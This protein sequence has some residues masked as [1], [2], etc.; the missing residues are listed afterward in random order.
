MIRLTEPGEVI[1]AT[2]P[3]PAWSVEIAFVELAEEQ[4][5]IVTAASELFNEYIRAILAKDWSKM[6][7]L[8]HPQYVYV[9]SNGEEHGGAAAARAQAEPFVTAFPDLQME[10]KRE[11]AAGDTSVFEFIAKGTH[12]GDLMGMAPTGKSVTMPVCNVIEVRDG[13]IY[14]E[15]EYYDT[16]HLMAQLGVS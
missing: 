8:L 11:Y 1:C 3:L 12:K 14:R 6:E 13:K 16:M 10:V 2:R 7:T 4:E 5:G 15:R 9:G